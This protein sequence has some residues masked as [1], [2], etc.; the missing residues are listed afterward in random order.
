MSRFSSDFQLFTLGKI[1]HASD[2]VNLCDL[3]P[4]PLIF[5]LLTYW[6]SLNLFKATGQ[7]GNDRIQK[8]K[9]LTQLSPSINT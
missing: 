5:K 1:G 8:K 3:R 4:Y 2:A 9:K 6:L 7:K